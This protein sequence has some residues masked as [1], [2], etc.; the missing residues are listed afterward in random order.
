MKGFVNPY[1][2]IDFPKKKAKVYT[3]DDTHTGYIEYTITTKTPLFIPN[4]SSDTAFEESDKVKDHK[5]YDFFSYT[6]LD[7]TKRY[8]GDY[9]VPVIPGSEIR[10]VMRNAYETLTD[11]CMGLLNE[12]EYPIRRSAARFESG[13]IYRNKLGSLSLYEA[14]SFRIGDKADKNSYPKGFEGYKNG[15]LLYYKIPSKD[16]KGC[17]NP[18]SDFAPE[19]KYKR[20]GYLLKWGMGVKKARYHLF[21]PRNDTR[22]RL[23]KDDIERKLLDVIES[24]LSQPT[25][26]KENENA[27]IEYKNDLQEFLNT[28]GEGYFPVNYSIPKLNS[29]ILYLSPAVYSKEIA[30]NDLGTL[31]GEFAPCKKG[32]CPAC[33]L[34]GYV[35]EEGARNSKI[36]FTDLYVTKE[37]KAKEYYLPKVTLQALG[38]PKLGNTEFYLKK[39]LGATFWTYDYY[40]KNEDVKIA[41][42]IL[43]GRKYYWHHQ[44]VNLKSVEAT[45]LNKTIRPLKDGISFKGKLYFE[46]ISEKQLK[47]LVWIL[48]SGSEGLGLKIGSAKPLGFGSISCEVLQVMERNITV[49]DGKLIYSIDEFPNYKD[50]YENVGFSKEVKAEFY[51]IAGLTTVPKDVEITYPKTIEQKDKEATEGFQWFVNNHKTVSGGGMAKNRADVKLE[52]ALPSIL[53]EDF[54]LAYNKT[55]VKKNNNFGKGNHKGGNYKGRKRY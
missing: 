50:S 23:N 25:V 15:T 43:R 44:K 40:V 54:S 37:Q 9:Y 16:D 35:T 47:Q 10:G 6:D 20:F 51:K 4:S 22:V 18:I 38:G 34:F 11:S 39:P 5:S 13:L 27:Y 29:K 26:T 12:Y 52:Q 2:F 36:R 48:N 8:D 46:G 21:E 28:R 3:D 19:G 1:N 32:E 30:Y 17:Y 33:D 55:P 49:Q 14:N 24:Y 45:N 31:A 41:K 7:Q 53:E 42:G